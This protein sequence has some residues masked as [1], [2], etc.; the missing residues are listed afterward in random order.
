MSSFRTCPHCGA[1]IADEKPGTTVD[2][3]DEIEW[4]EFSDASLQGSPSPNDVAAGLVANSELSEAANTES[5]LASASSTPTDVPA[6]FAPKAIEGERSLENPRNEADRGAEKTGQGPDW[7][8]GLFA[9]ASEL[10]LVALRTPPSGEVASTV[11]HTEHDRASALRSW[12]MVLVTSYA[13]ALTIALWWL[14]STGRVQWGPRYPRTEAREGAVQT[15]RLPEI[16]LEHRTT[17]GKSLRVGDLEITPLSVRTDDVWLRNVTSSEPAF[18]KGGMDSLWLRLR[19]RNLSTADSFVPL[20]VNFVRDPDRGQG[21]SVVEAETE[22]LP[23]FPLAL[24]SEWDIDGE[25]FPHLFLKQ[26]SKERFGLVLAAE[27]KECKSASGN[28]KWDNEAKHC[29]R[30]SESKSVKYNPHNCRRQ[31]DPSKGYPRGVHPLGWTLEA[32]Q[33][34][35]CRACSSSNLAGLL[36]PS[37]EWRRLVL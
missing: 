19:I 35:T 9:M 23:M 13:S 29:G 37:A 16:L 12:S 20:E 33:M 15:A 34:A 26:C 25:D 36:Y 11:E 2:H 28:K 32:V 8:A 17:L 27:D 31:N 3:G 22:L 14:V 4:A 24:S 10:G 30:S 5:L 6:A 18:R 21:D 1:L 7:N